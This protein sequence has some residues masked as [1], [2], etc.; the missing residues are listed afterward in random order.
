[1]VHRVLDV[2]L[3]TATA[4]LSELAR[5][6]ARTGAEVVLTVDAEPVAR[7]LPVAPPP[8]RLT[9]PEVVLA[10]A[11]MRGLSRIPRASGAFDALALLDDVR[12]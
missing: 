2:P 9:E 3:S 4:K 5:S 1:M 12:R 8:R 11:L 6:V 10:R 7:L